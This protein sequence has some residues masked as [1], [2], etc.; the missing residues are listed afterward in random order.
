MKIAELC[1]RDV[2]IAPE[3]TSA[4]Q[5]AKLMREFHTGSVL[6]TRETGGVRKPVGIV[7][8]RDIVVEL[9]AKGVDPNTCMA[10]DM[11]CGELICAAENDDVKDVMERMRRHGIRRMPV[12]DPRGALVGIVTADDLIDYVWEQLDDLVALVRREQIKE[13]ATRP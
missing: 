6:I 5:L 4:G 1:N 12:V 11:L 2:V 3:Q 13:Q 8:D 7:T 9:V 10:N